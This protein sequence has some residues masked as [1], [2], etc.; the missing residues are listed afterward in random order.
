M[1][2]LTATATAK[3]VDDIQTQLT[4]QQKNVFRMSFERHNLAYIVRKTNNKI[5]ELI[6]ILSCT[7]GSAIVYVRSRRRSKELSAILESN[8]IPSTV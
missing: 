6:H 3:V 4:F 8:G 2:A 1:L 5:S 7:S